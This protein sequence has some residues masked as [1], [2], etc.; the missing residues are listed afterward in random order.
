M[1]SPFVFPGH[2]DACSTCKEIVVL[3]S[4]F[5][6]GST[7][8]NWGCFSLGTRLADIEWLICRPSGKLHKNVVTRLMKEGE[9]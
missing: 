5:I 7:L 6:Q 2:V 1:L 9:R 3:P 8:I 4:S